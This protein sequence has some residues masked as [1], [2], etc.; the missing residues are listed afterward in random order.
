MILSY[1]YRLRPNKMQAAALTEMLG[2][3][4]ELY[5]AALEHRISA[6]HRSGISISCFDQIKAMPEIRRDLPHQGRWSATAQQ[7]VLRRLDNAYRAFFRRTMRSERAGFPRFRSRARYHAAD[8]CVGDGLTLRQSGKIRFCGI[9]DEVKVIWHRVMPSKPKSAILSRNAGKWF[10]VFHVDVAPQDRAGPESIGIDFGLTSLVALSNGET[11]ERVNVTRRHASKLRR[12]NRALARCKR[13]SKLR[14][15]RKA[16]LAGCHNNIRSARRD[17][18]HKL[19]ASIVSR[20]GRIAIE[21]LN[22]KGLAAGPLAKHV[23]DAAWSTLAAMLAYKAERAG[24]ELVRVDPRGTSQTCPCCGTIAKK[25]LAE[26]V[27]RCDCG[28]VLDRDVAAAMVIHD[29]AFGT[30]PG[31]GR[32]SLSQ[33][34]AAA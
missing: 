19:S 2:D 33:Q 10:I 8:F 13:G 21:D 32:E 14:A 17:I 34:S 22:V 1:K 9:R 30:R 29:R 7:R 5:N 16:A 18:L 26:R 23:K 28:A 11:A 27:H 25:T 3:F 24:C 31:A 20:F 4:C 15:K 12:L 6:Y